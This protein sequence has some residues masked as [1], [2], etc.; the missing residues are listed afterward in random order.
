MIER[1]ATGPTGRLA[2]FLADPDGCPLPTVSGRLE[3]T[4][5]EAEHL[6]GP[7][8]RVHPAWYEPTEWL[9]SAAPGQLH[10]VTPMPSTR[11]HSQF[12]AL[13]A[14]VPP[15]RLNAVTARDVGVS[16]GQEVRVVNDRG[17]CAARI[18][19]T[20]DVADGVLVIE[21]GRWL[22]VDVDGHCR[23]GNVNVV[24][25]DRP[26]SSWGQATAAHSCLVRLEPA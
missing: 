13:E 3:I 10:L 1:S 5:G 15:A 22:D 4:V 20:P 16:D 7:G 11:L 19:V 18:V 25:S 17:S 14:E 9:G 8:A 23:R 24:T 2:A 6:L 21:N 26:T 12:A